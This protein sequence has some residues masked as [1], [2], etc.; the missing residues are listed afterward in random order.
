MEG[1][2]AFWVDHQKYK[3]PLTHSDW[4]NKG[5][6]FA[7]TSILRNDQ[8]DLARVKVV[9]CQLQPLLRGSYDVRVTSVMDRHVAIA[10]HTD[11]SNTNR[12]DWRAT[13]DT[14]SYSMIELPPRISQS[15]SSLMREL[16]IQY[17]AS[18]FIVTA[19]GDWY[20]LEANPHGAWLWMETSLGSSPIT[21]LFSETFQNLLTE[22][23]CWCNAHKS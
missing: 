10:V 2:A 8:A 1:F 14:A 5:S 22:V 16:K 18:D 17:C 13:Q 3:S 11:D 12:H 21:D 6:P 23:W 15:L 7:Y 20:F 9:P 19:N 4:F